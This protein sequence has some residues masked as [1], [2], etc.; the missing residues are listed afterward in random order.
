M[1]MSLLFLLLSSF[2]LQF[3]LILESLCLSHTPALSLVMMLKG[4]NALGGLEGERQSDFWRMVNQRWELWKGKYSYVLHLCPVFNC[5]CQTCRI[6]GAHTV[7][8][9]HIQYIHLIP[10]IFVVFSTLEAAAVFSLASFPF[11]F[12]FLS[13]HHHPVLSPSLPCCLK[14]F[15]R[16]QICGMSLNFPWGDRT[17]TGSIFFKS[18]KHVHN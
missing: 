18:S 13:S 8:H 5:V 10:C 6:C 17:L 12:L 7:R 3:S 16:F 1:K 9:Q 4:S 14:I 15:T 11:L 2:S